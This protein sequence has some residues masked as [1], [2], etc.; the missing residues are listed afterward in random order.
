M[1]LSALLVAAMLGATPSAAQDGS[2]SSRGSEKSSAQDAAQPA[3]PVS[4]DHIR[5]ALKKPADASMLR[6]AELPSDFRVEIVEQQKID[7]MLSKLD[8]KS[9]PV[10]AGGLYGFEQ[11]QRLFRPTDR[12]LMQPYAAFNG[13]QL[14]TIALENLLLR[15]LGGRV[16][17][18]LSD[19][20]RSRAERAAREE[21]DEAIGAYCASRPDRTQIQL[22]TDAAIAR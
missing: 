7:E 4:L 22:C 6:N 20:E 2:S 12:P 13:G 18:A 16:M 5:E 1:R 21:V 3:L 9:G 15:Y 8:F 11:Q 14:I 17:D 19:A 10:P